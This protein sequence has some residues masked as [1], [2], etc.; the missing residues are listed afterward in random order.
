MKLYSEIQVQLIN[1][2]GFRFGQF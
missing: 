1:K 2:L